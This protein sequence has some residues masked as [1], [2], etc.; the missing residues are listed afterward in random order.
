MQALQAFLEPFRRSRKLRAAAVALFTIV[1]TALLN[2]EAIDPNTLINAIVLLAGAYMGTVA[3]EDTQ[4]A[5]ANATVAAANITAHSQATT[6]TVSTPGTSEVQV[7]QA[8]TV[9]PAKLP[10]GTYTGGH[11]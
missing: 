11:P 10:Y 2:R 8:D 7:T 5:R 1:M 4:N 9:V 6:T 3:W